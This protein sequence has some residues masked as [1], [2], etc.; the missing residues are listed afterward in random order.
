MQFVYPSFLF[1]LLALAIPIIIH[2]FYFRRFKKVYFTNVRFLKEVKEETS[3]RSKL[4]NLLVLAMRLLALGLL[5][6]AFAQPFIPRDVEVKTGQKAVSV[7][8]DNSFSMNA[9]SEDAALMDKAK[10]RAR[11]IVAAY[12]VEDQFQILSNDFEGRH[13]RMVSQED[14]L[15][16]ID[17]ISSSP[18]VKKLSQVLSRQQQALNTS[19]L[20]NFV[21]YQISDF[22]KNITDLST[23]TD[24]LTE[25]NLIPLQSV[26]ERNIS[27][28][29]AWF[30]SP[31][32]MLNQ[33]NPLMVKV[34]NLSAE[35]AENIRLS[36][37]YDGQTKPVG[38]LSI[39]A[40]SSVIDTVNF[41][42]NRTGWYTAELAITDFPVQFDDKYFISFNVAEKINV[43]VVN[44]STPNRYLEAAFKGISYFN[45]TSLSSQNL[46]YSSFSNY[47]MIVLNGLNAISSGFS[48]ELQEYVKE[49]GNLLAFPGRNASVPSYQ[50]FLQAIPANEL[51]SWQEGSQQV[52]N[53]NTEEFIFN[54]VFENRSANLNL[55]QSNGNFKTTNYSSRQ[56]EILMAYR[57]GSPFLSKYRAGKGHLYFCTAPLDEEWNNLVRNGEIF[58]P[59][60]YKMSISAGESRPI[61]YTI[62]K[63]DLIQSNHQGSSGDIVYKLQ[64]GG[65]EFIPEQRI[66]GSTVFL[67]LNNQLRT[68]GFYQLFLN[69]ENILDRFA[70]NFDRQESVLTYYTSDELQELVGEQASIIGTQNNEVLT[71][72]IAERSQG[73]ILW[74]WCLIFALLFLLAEVVLLR[75]W[76]V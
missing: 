25:L 41:T 27:I 14:A 7:F 32:Q 21:V 13:Q 72:K 8:L 26:E 1:A 65:E 17:E 60:L 29:S 15:N 43:L 23:Y 3:A 16:L 64:G 73:V 74:R 4:R 5:V 58:I 44:E 12:S 33:T 71:A 20:E 57:D 9:L 75:F 50:S 67:S 69:E 10:Q 70:F 42:V 51:M 28:D 61:A 36:I 53:I 54:D 49:G 47:Q 24:T 56:E 62:G 68:A 19:T 31:V 59:M 76:K 52:G 40:N 48:F 38:T 18:S 30:E 11:E 39:P 63:N 35:D 66:V 55:P 6:F 34:R 37:N 45:L 22:Q 2:L 46:D